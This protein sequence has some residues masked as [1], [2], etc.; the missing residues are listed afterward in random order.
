MVDAV[1]L[2]TLYRCT[3]KVLLTSIESGI[4]V[5][6]FTHA[7]QDGAAQRHLRDG[8]DSLIFSLDRECVVSGGQD[9]A[10][11]VFDV[12]EAG[13]R[14]VHRL[15][16]RGGVRRALERGLHRNWV[17]CLGMS[18]QTPAE[19]FLV[20]GSTAGWLRVWDVRASCTKPTRRF[21]VSGSSPKPVAGVHVEGQRHLLLTA[22]FD[23]LVKSWDTRTWRMLGA[24][25]PA[26]GSR[27]T[28]LHFDQDS[29]VVGTFSEQVCV[30]DFV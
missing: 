7:P 19:G 25:S 15:A 20:D 13:G 27:L 26:G 30:A 17:W 5:A 16:E 24:F 14:R 22:S 10:V 23:G 3:G 6:S 12:H 2:P 21:A 4:E 28:R 18:G 9:G 1:A 8:A 29:V 11:S